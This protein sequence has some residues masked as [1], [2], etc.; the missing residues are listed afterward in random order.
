MQLLNTVSFVIE[1]L[2]TLSEYLSRISLFSSISLLAIVMILEWGAGVFLLQ[3][4]EGNVRKERS[5]FLTEGHFN[6]K[7]PTEDGRV[8]S[9]GRFT[10]HTILEDLHLKP[11]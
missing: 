11:L 10:P 4:K 2:R 3:G 8:F 6:T 5:F 9:Y 1:I 7:H